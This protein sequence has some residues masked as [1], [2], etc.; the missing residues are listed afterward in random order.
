MR[1]TFPSSF[2]S[3]GS[4]TGVNIGIPASSGRSPGLSTLWTPPATRHE[5]EASHQPLT[6]E[7]AGHRLARSVQ[8]ASTG[9]APLGFPQMHGLWQQP[10]STAWDADEPSVRSTAESSPVPCRSVIPPAGK[11][12]S[13]E[14][15]DDTAYTRYSIDA[16]ECA[17]PAL[18]SCLFIVQQLSND[19]QTAPRALRG[20]TP[21]AA[22][23]SAATGIPRP[24]G[25]HQTRSNSLPRGD[26]RRRCAGTGVRLS[27]A[28]A[29]CS[30][31]CTMPV[32][33][34]TYRK[35][36]NSMSN[37]RT[38]FTLAKTNDYRL[39]LGPTAASRDDISTTLILPCECDG[40]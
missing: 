36:Y 24:R 35:Q 21:L 1:N 10:S 29:K 39:T 7:G 38:Q 25:R 37:F 8:D 2:C 33:T 17:H 23:V 30:A 14:A 26:V 6:V 18:P 11:P 16:I 34:Y 3:F 15:V 22:T 19:S 31:Y 28:G 9:M 5:G 4:S 32:Q 40:P 27:R 20:M 12:G 13:R